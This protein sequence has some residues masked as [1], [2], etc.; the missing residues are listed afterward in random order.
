MEFEIKLVPGTIFLSTTPYRMAIPK[1]VELKKQLDELLGKGFIRPSMSPWATSILFMKK[2]DGTLRLCIDYKEL[3]A[4]T[5]K[6]KYLL[7][8]IQDLFDQL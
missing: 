7:P 5:I 2:T 4:L 1:T 8:R 6:N 3:N